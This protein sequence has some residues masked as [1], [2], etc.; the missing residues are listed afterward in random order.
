[1]HPYNFNSIKVRLELHLQQNIETETRFQFHKGTIRTFLEIWFLQNCV[2]FNSIKVRL[3][4]NNLLCRIVQKLYFNSIKVRLEH[5]SPKIPTLSLKYFNSI[6]VRLEHNQ[7]GYTYQFNEFQFH[8]GTI[9]TYY[10]YDLIANLL[11]ISIP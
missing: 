4:L 5:L 8:K 10:T 9:R 7:N 1:M 11:S 3:E 2:Y 6:K